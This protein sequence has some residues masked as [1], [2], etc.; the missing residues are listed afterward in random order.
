MNLIFDIGYNHGDFSYA[1]KEKYPDCKIIALEANKKLYEKYN[2]KIDGVTLLN[3]LV[4]DS[5]NEIKNFYIN[6][7][8]GI[9]TS[10][11]EFIHKSRFAV[12]SKYVNNTGGW[13]NPVSVATKTLD[14]IIKQYGIPDLIKI[15]VEGYENTVL[16]GLSCKVP[17]ICF[18]AH[19]ELIEE[20]YKCLDRLL[21][22]GYTEYG[23]IGLFDEGDVFEDLTYDKSGDPYMTLPNKFIS[24]DRMKNALSKFNPDRA[25]NYGMVYC[26]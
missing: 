21:Y 17:M 20:A 12:G 7:Q 19:E 24:Y 1:V 9:S 15:D 26:R 6:Y 18:E 22:L 25:V 11:L 8:D 5:D 4:S 10:S 14:T 2:T 3:N 16:K 13:S 23:M